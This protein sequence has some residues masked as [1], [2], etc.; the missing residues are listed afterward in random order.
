MHTNRLQSSQKC[1]LNLLLILCIQHN[2]FV[3][4]IEQFKL[5]HSQRTPSKCN[6][7]L[8]DR[9]RPLLLHFFCVWLWIHWIVVHFKKTREGERKTEEFT[10]NAKMIS[11]KRQHTTSKQTDARKKA[12]NC[13]NVV[14]ACVNVVNG[15]S[16]FDKFKLVWH[17]DRAKEF[18]QVLNA[19][20][21]G[22]VL[23]TDKFIHL[24]KNNFLLS[25]HAERC[26]TVWHAYPKQMKRAAIVMLKICQ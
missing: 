5:S 24:P 8:N 7:E 14:S 11:D 1:R 9:L 22:S 20:Q 16:K 18:S 19:E 21:I 4:P 6:H 26:H 15:S 17:F 23:W 3:V 2:D 25:I 10:F 12:Q 13:S